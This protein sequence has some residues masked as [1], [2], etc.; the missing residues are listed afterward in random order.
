[1]ILYIK[2]QLTEIIKIDN[3]NKVLCEITNTTEDSFTVKIN[4]KNIQ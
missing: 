3:N 1:M 2:H 4:S